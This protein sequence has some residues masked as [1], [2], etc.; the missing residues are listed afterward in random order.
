MSER[1][2]REQPPG[3]GIADPGSEQDS[4]ALQLFGVLAEYDTAERLLR[5]ARE[6]RDLG[7]RH[8]DTFTPYPVHGVDAA[9]GIRPTRLPWLVAAAG[10]IGCLTAVVLQWW[11]NAFDYPWIVSGKPLWSVPA[12]IPITFELTVLF[13]AITAMVGMLVLNGLP[14]PSHP[15]DLKQRFARVTDDRFFLLIEASDGKFDPEVTREHLLGTHAVAVESVENDQQSSDRLPRGLVASLVVLGAAAIV[16]FAWIAKARATPSRNPRIHVVR[17][18]DFQ[19]KFKAQTQ[20]SFYP[21][22]Q[23]ARVPVRGTIAIGE[24][25][26]DDHLFRGRRGTQ[27]AT[28]LPAQ[29]PPTEETMRRGQQ[30]FDI[31]CA[32]CHGLT[33]DGDGMVAQRATALG[34][35]TWVPPT[36]VRQDTIRQQPA[37]QLFNTITHGIRT[38]PGYGPL[39]SPRDRWAIVMYLRALQRSQYASIEDVAETGRQQ[40][41]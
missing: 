1:Q 35:G 29:I 31:Y 19:P 8:F 17:D 2:E 38:M 5:A 20:N 36:D 32:P 34:Q 40:L 21:D 16:P 12:T 39:L 27:W 6:V 18:M 10:L 9:M 15:L 30:R 28:A 13:A 22:Q 24:L 14:H 25:R 33:G 11:T 4:A 26:T 3:R 37:G 23:A 41:K 7:Y